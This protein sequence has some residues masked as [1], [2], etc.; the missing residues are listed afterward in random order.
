MSVG[1]AALQAILRSRGV[2]MAQ[3]GGM[4]VPANFGSAAGELSA[5]VVAV[6]IADRSDLGK[7]VVTG[8][9][10]KLHAFV[11]RHTGV[12][13]SPGG[14]VAMA[15]GWWCADGVDRLLVL[16]APC[17]R[18]RVHDILRREA[19]PRRIAVLDVSEKLTCVAV[20]G[21]RM[22]DLLA[23][24]AIVPP[25]DDLRSLAPYSAGELA[26]Q[27]V[28]LLLESDRR[29]LLIT[30]AAHADEVWRALEIAG[31]PLGLSLIGLDALER[32]ALFEK[33]HLGRTSVL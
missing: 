20:A 5:C 21:H 10:S 28:N 1:N 6:G 27:R 26:G 9:H 32:F 3:R 25:T 23:A 31:R 33:L 18:T 12:A 15:E 13:L 17:L 8:P 24:S 2:V 4:S 16:G 30:E 14:V 22:P 29:A 7:L 11:S 19:R